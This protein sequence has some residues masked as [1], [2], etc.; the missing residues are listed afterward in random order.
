MQTRRFVLVSLIL[1]ALGLAACIATPPVTTTTSTGRFEAT[2][3]YGP[4][5]GLS[6]NGQVRL[7]VGASGTVSGILK[8][9]DGSQVKAV[10]QA[11]GRAI[12]L[13]FDLGNDQKVFGV[14]TTER[15]I[16]EGGGMMGGPFSGPRAGDLGDWLCV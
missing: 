15:D 13:M 11:N 16:R 12:N 9:G 3:H 10:G 4:D 6:L 2:V 5:A 1:L 14:G 8:L 7:E